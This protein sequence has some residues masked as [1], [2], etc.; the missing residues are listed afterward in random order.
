MDLQIT[1]RRFLRQTIGFSAAV[2]A[3]QALPAIAAA[4]HGEADLLM[5]GDWGYAR[6]AAQE[7][8]AAGMVKYA[9][10]QRLHAQA[11]LMLGDNWYDEL[12]GGVDSPRWKT[13]FEDLYPASVFPGL[14]Y[15]ILGNHDYQMYPTS[16]VEAELLKVRAKLADENFAAKVPANVLEEHRQREKNWADKLGQLQRMQDALAS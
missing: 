15:A 6:P 9:Q 14:A 3:S 12:P 2:L 11:L 8:V 10:A 7:L 5:V 13:H 4:P 1:R 16:K